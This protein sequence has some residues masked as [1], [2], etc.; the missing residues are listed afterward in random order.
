MNW[1]LPT[2]GPKTLNGLI[3]DFMET[4]PKSGISIKLHGHPLEII[5]RDENAV[6]L[7]KFLP[8]K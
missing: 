4:I 5:K 2:E 1:S 3:V 7:V 6:K 8:E